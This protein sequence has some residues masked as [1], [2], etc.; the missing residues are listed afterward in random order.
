MGAFAERIKAR[1]EELRLTQEQVATQVSLTNTYISAIENGTKLPPPYPVVKGLAHALEMD[2]R[3]LWELAEKERE[4]RALERV[5]GDRA[6]FRRRLQAAGSSTTTKQASYPEE[7]A[8]ILEKFTGA[9]RNNGL[10]YL[11]IVREILDDPE[12]ARAFCNL[13]KAVT[14]RGQRQML[15]KAIEAIVDTA[16]N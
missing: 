5:K 15:L 12:F 8:A 11:D 6:S 16:Q 9:V 10:D 4:A 13:K 2:E 7:V 14:D 1:R 3:E